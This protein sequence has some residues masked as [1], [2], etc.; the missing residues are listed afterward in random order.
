MSTDKKV[1]Y[2]KFVEPHFK[3]T[4][5]KAEDF[6]E[7][8]DYSDLIYRLRQP[9]DSNRLQQIYQQAFIY[10]LLYGFAKDKLP[11]AKHANDTKNSNKSQATDTTID[12]IR[13]QV[14]DYLFKN[15]IH[16]ST[17]AAL[18]NQ[19][20]FVN[21]KAEHPSQNLWN[22]EDL[23]I[24]RK[25]FDSIKQ[26]N[27]SLRAQLALANDDKKALRDNYDKLLHD[28][29]TLPDEVRALEK[30]N[31]RLYIRV[32]E[33]EKSYKNNLDEMIALDKSY[34]GALGEAAQ[35]RK[36][37]HELEGEKSRAQYEL[38]KYEQGAR[39]IKTELRLEYREKLNAQ[40]Q[41]LGKE[42]HLLT[43]QKDT[44]SKEL[45]TEK[46]DHDRCKKALSQLRVHFM[47]T[48]FS[49]LNS[50][51]QIDDSKLQIN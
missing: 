28:T 9:I 5:L 7:K 14:L 24:L 48:D 23:N 2:T 47:T 6:N 31:E 22:T 18:E 35:A 11:T 34:R 13:D 1:D 33:V 45:Q 30:S 17:D 8:P 12:S 3:Y 29:K 20:V 27:Y 16:I 38:S 15:H 39:S 42:I 10:D 51:D 4:D 49:N 36:K 32:Q 43:R 37:C 41:K 50:R 21:E 44:I 26:E 40:K 19:P 46:A 25:R